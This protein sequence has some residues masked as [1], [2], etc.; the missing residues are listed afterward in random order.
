VKPVPHPGSTRRF[1]A[2]SDWS[3]EQDGEC[4]T[5]EIADV[6]GAGGSFMESLWR[7][8][9]EEL[10]ALN[11][12]GAIILGIRGDVHPVIYLGVT[13]PPKHDGLEAA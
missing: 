2:P 13:P 6:E 7:P 11:A 9:D 10:A 4:S 8:N 3:T 12:G 5:L 1:G